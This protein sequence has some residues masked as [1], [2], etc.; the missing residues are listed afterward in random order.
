MLE[1]PWNSLRVQIF[2]SFQIK[3]HYT[4][5]QS[6]SFVAITWSIS[7]CIIM[8]YCVQIVPWRQTGYDTRIDTTLG[9]L[10]MGCLDTQTIQSP[11]YCFISCTLFWKTNNCLDFGSSYPK[12]FISCILSSFP[13]KNLKENE[14]LIE[15]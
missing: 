12:I 1:L 2:C 10:T 4:W 3:Y 14:I 7:S 13:L 5:T 8:C 6:F 9:G 11:F 15:I